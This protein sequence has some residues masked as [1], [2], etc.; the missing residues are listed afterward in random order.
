MTST[1][2]DD[3]WGVYRSGIE[4]RL[5]SCAN[6]L[7]RLRRSVVGEIARD[8]HYFH[9][10]AHQLHEAV[11]VL[12]RWGQDIEPWLR[13]CD[14]TVEQKEDGHT[15]VGTCECPSGH[16]GLHDDDPR[17]GVGR[18]ALPAGPR[19]RGARRASQPSPPVGCPCRR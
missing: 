11:L 15:V 1:D 8:R 5:A 16:D 19:A 13:A 12:M 17:R 9:D 18:A 2:R 6:Y 3:S 14:A 7:D 10:K 4:F